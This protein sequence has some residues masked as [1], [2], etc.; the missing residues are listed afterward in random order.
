[1]NARAAAIAVVA[2]QLA[3]CAPAVRADI[4][5]LANQG[6]LRGQLLNPE[7]TPR[8]KYVV[9]TSSGAVVTL[10]R[11]QVVKLHRETSRELEYEKRMPTHADTVDSQWEL[12]EWCREN[13]LN[14]QR[15]R[16]LER[17]LELDPNHVLARRA[18]NYMQIDG[19]WKTREQV[20]KDR[21]FV[22]YNGEW[23][24]PQ[25]IE[26]LEKQ[27]KDKLAERQW[28]GRLNKL[29]DEL[30]SEKAAEA[31]AKLRA[32][33]DPYA[34]K[35]I[36]EA[37]QTEPNQQVRIWLLES[38]TKIP[39]P[40]ATMLLVGVA[41]HDGIEE[42][43]LS[44]LDFL[45]EQKNP[46]VPAMFIAA[47]K[48]NNVQVINRAAHA[49]KR[50]KHP[51]AIG[52]LIDALVSVQKID[53]VEGQPG[54]IGATFGKGPGGTGGGGLSV[55]QSVRTEYRTIQNPEVLD[56]LIKLTGNNFEHNVNAWK[57]WFAQQKKP[58]TLDGR[59]G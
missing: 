41:L 48:D 39:S 1:M 16:H 56:A 38:L 57:A 2:S 37:L 49:L 59:R 46:E 36:A 22:R 26:L 54:G 11:A 34:L 44:A 3:L 8:K 19:G 50:L 23:K 17:I 4:F 32:I 53:I 13:K 28:F 55:G 24:L 12:A 5:Q 9:R 29:R 21:G 27:K 40:E 35:A 20:Q 52:P 47:L 14:A 7:E 43:R 15:N 33:N 25:E 42:V 30:H 58:E 10:D 45:V 31:T 51:A 18:L 6:T